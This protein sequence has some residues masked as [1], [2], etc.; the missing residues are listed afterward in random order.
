MQ[1]TDSNIAPNDRVAV[2]AT[3]PLT[4]NEDWVTMEPGSLWLFHDG[5]VVSHRATQRPKVAVK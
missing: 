2:V 4:D 1:P 3:Q 5:E